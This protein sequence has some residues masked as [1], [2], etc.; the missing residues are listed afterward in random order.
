MNLEIQQ[1]KP[2]PCPKCGGNLDLDSSKTLAICQHCQS[3]FL[4]TEKELV[5]LEEEDLKETVL[6]P[7]YLNIVSHFCASYYRPLDVT[8]DYFYLSGSMKSSFFY[9]KKMKEAKLSFHIPEEDDVFLYENISTDFSKIN[10]GFALC[11]S[12]FYYLETEDFPNN[13]GMLTWQ[14][15]KQA[16]IWA[17]GK[18]VL[19]INN[20]Y[21]LYC[22]GPQE[23]AHVLKLIQ[24]SI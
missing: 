14:E 11:T 15:F 12:G 4:L 7:D 9:K 21:F 5:M 24:R 16:K 19:L 1:R 8:P 18:D 2:L 23:V 22:S 13:Y 10:A 20:L 17:A 3:A 6:H